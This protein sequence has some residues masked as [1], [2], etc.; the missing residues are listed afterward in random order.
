MNAAQRLTSLPEALTPQRFDTPAILKKLVRAHRSLAELKGIAA[1]IPNQ[2]L[3]IG[4]L[5][6]QE[7]KESSA[8][9]NIVTTQDELFRGDALDSPNSAAAKEVRLYADALRSGFDAV[10]RQRL[11]TGNHILDIQSVLEP[12]RAGYRKVL[13]TTLKD[14]AGRV[15]YTPPSPE[16]LPGLMGDL[17]RFINDDALFDAD[18]LVKMALIHHQFE[19]IHPFYDGNGRTGRIV[20]V[21]YLVKE[22]LLDIPVLYLS[23]AIVRTKP[24]YYA[25][26]Q[27]VRDRGA[28]EEWVLYML[29]AVDETATEGITTIRGI[30]ILLLDYKHRIRA[31]HRFYSQ[32]LI[33]NLFAFPYT[34]IEFIQRD[35]KVSRITATRYLEV[36]TEDGLLRKRKFGR[37][38]YYI[39]EPLF[40]ILTG[41]S[42][43]AADA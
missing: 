14:A 11:L 37:S 27:A 23:R 29:G 43:P 31:K 35:L 1:S 15:V 34:K 38:N 30:K 16:L 4:T 7:A 5:S 33:N 20:N 2:A 17:E 12:S 9:E 32:D 42:P 8:I 22:Q 25:K 21:L 36:L 24:D 19:S 26:L 10:R 28:W 39:N 6:L 18:P 13:G 3:L 41:E 40:R